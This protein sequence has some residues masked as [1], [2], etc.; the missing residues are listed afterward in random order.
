MNRPAGLFTSDD[1]GDSW[2]DIT[3]ESRPS[4]ML[5]SFVE[6]PGSFVRLTAIDETVFVSAIGL[7]LRSTDAGGTWEALFGV[8]DSP[9]SFIGGYIEAAL[10]ADTFFIVGSIS[11]G[12]S[13]SVRSMGIGRSADG[14]KTWHPFLTGMA[15]T[16]CPPT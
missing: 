12:R 13:H 1:F 6:L 2:K 4:G 11:V 8:P 7:L 3:P 10:D 5:G 15:E 9:A 16:P 14:G